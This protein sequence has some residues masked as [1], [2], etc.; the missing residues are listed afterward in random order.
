MTET[1]TQALKAFLE[2]SQQFRLGNLVTEQSHPKTADL[3][4]SVHKN[5]PAAVETLLEIDR[6]ALGI[7]TDAHADICALARACADCWEQGGRVFLGGCGAT[8]RLSLSLEV[9]LRQER[10][11]TF[12][13]TPV[14]AFMAG[15]DAALVRSIEAF[16]DHPEH[17]ARQLEELSFRDGDLFIGI[18]EGGETPHVI[19][20]TECAVGLSHHDAWFCYCNP[21]TL[22]VPVAERSARVLSNQR[23]RK[24]NLTVGPM[25][26]SGS[27]RMQASTVQMAAVGLALFYAFD[28]ESIAAHIERFTSLPERIESQALAALIRCEHTV[29]SKNGY[30]RYLTDMH[31]I[32]VL[33]DTTERSPTFSLTA[34]ENAKNP[35]QPP[36]LCTLTIKHSSCSAQAWHTLLGRTPRCLEWGFCQANTSLK[37]LY[38]YDIS[39]T[40]PRCK[41]SFHGRAQSVCRIEEEDDKL[42][43]Q[44]DNELIEAP[45]R[46]LDLL[47]RHLLLKLM[48]N[49]HSTL[50][51]GLLGRYEGN[52]MTYVRPSNYKLIDRAIRYVQAL[53]PSHGISPPDYELCAKALFTIKDELA[54]NEPIVLRVLE[55][56]NNPESYARR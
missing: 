20:A 14:I 19:G 7:L 34:F 45:T 37:T 38:G 28:P 8:G 21:D 53:A 12:E 36:S 40:S 41:E 17:G 52:R 2:A 22:L 3:S 13:K 9:L 54:E 50:V 23:I 32:T 47:G 31:G 5:T 10:R 51:M 43:M 39:A 16:E 18:T 24:L 6:D 33:T 44:I 48:L 11:E 49:T 29:Y 25:A 46:Q 35:K 56:L 42:S 15:G 30:M 27:T 55:K 26:L 4:Q 1:Q